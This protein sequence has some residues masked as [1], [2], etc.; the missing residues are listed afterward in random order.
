MKRKGI[1]MTQNKNE[2]DEAKRDFE[3]IKN[4]FMLKRDGTAKWSIRHMRTIQKAL[5]FTAE[6][7]RIVD[8]VTSQGYTFHKCHECGA[9][10]NNHHQ[11]AFKAMITK[12]MEGNDDE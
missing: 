6:A 4:V 1:S 3:D 7:Q 12:M 8:G 11:R 9:R 2:Y 5:R 10:D